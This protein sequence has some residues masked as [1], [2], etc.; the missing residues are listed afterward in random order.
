MMESGL[1]ILLAGAYFFYPLL[2]C[3]HLLIHLMHMIQHAVEGILDRV[4]H[5]LSLSIGFKADLPRHGLALCCFIVFLFF[6]NHM[7][8]Y[9]HHR[10]PRW[11]VLYHDRVATDVC[12][13]TD[14]NRP[15]HLGTCPDHDIILQGGMAFALVPGSAAQGHAMID[16][17][18]ISDLGGLADDN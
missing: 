11:Y 7:A 14:G 6:H 2:Q 16:R 5:V 18:I 9:S 15:E 3:L 1:S 4:G 13:V 12:P 10:C 8:G 17:Y